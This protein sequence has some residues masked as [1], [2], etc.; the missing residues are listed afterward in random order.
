MSNP[1]K[2]VPI[3]FYHNVWLFF[4]LLLPLQLTYILGTPLPSNFV[5][6][7]KSGC[8]CVSVC[9]PSLLRSQPWCHVRLTDCHNKSSVVLDTSLPLTSRP[10]NSTPTITSPVDI[11]RAPYAKTSFTDTRHSEDTE[12]SSALLTDTQAETLRGFMHY[13]AEFLS[14]VVSPSVPT[15]RY[16]QSKPTRDASCECKEDIVGVWDYCVLPAHFN[17]D[18][19]SNGVE[20]YATS[21]LRQQR[22]NRTTNGL[23]SLFS[24]SSAGAS[25]HPDNVFQKNSVFQNTFLKAPTGGCHPSCDTCLDAHYPPETG[26]LRCKRMDERLYQ[27]IPLRPS[28]PHGSCIPITNSVSHCHMSCASCLDIGFPNNASSCVTCPAGTFFSPGVVN[29]VGECIEKPSLVTSMPF[30]ASSFFESLQNV[31]DYSQRSWLQVTP[32]R[33][34]TKLPSDSHTGTNRKE[35]DVASLETSPTLERFDSRI[36]SVPQRLTNGQRHSWRNDD[37]R[38]RG[39]S[40]I[41]TPSTPDKLPFNSL[42]EAEQNKR[43]T[44]DEYNINLR[45]SLVLTEASTEHCNAIREYL[46]RPLPV[47]SSSSYPHYSGNE[48]AERYWTQLV[49]LQADTNIQESGI[50]NMDEMLHPILPPDFADNLGF[51][52]PADY[53]HLVVLLDTRQAFS[54]AANRSTPFDTD[55]SG[56]RQAF[57]QS[58]E[59]K[60]TGDSKQMWSSLFSSSRSRSNDTLPYQLQHLVICPNLPIADHVRHHTIDPERG[61]AFELYRV[62]KYDTTQHR[63]TANYQ[64]LL[65][66]RR[67]EVDM[68]NPLILSDFISRSIQLFPASYVS[69][70]LWNHGAAWRG[71]GDD[72]DNADGEGM[73]LSTIAQGLEQ[74][75]EYPRQENILNRLTLLGFDACL[76]SEFTVVNALASYTDYFLAS[77]DNEPIRGWDWRFLNPVVQETKVDGNSWFGAPMEYRAATPVEYASQIIKGYATTEQATLRL[78]NQML[79]RFMTLSLIEISAFER[80]RNHFYL[81]CE[82]LYACGGHRISTHIQRVVSRLPSIAAC[83]TLGLCHCM[84]MDRFLTSLIEELLAEGMDRRIV[85][86]VVATRE[87]YHQ[88]VIYDVERHWISSAGGAVTQPRYLVQQENDGTKIERLRSGLSLYFPSHE[89]QCANNTRSDMNAAHYQELFDTGWSQFLRRVMS[90]ERGKTCTAFYPS[91]RLAL[92][93]LESSMSPLVNANHQP[94][95]PNDR[96]RVGITSVNI[97]VSSSGTVTPVYEILFSGWVPRM[98]LATR[99]LVGVTLDRLPSHL[100]LRQIDQQP[101]VLLTREVLHEKH[102]PA[103]RLLKDDEDVAFNIQGAWDISH[104]VLVQRWKDETV[105]KPATDHNEDRL[106]APL[107][108]LHTR[109]LTVEIPG[110]SASTGSEPES[111][112]FE[113][114]HLASVKYYASVSDLDADVF[115]LGYLLFHWPKRDTPIRLILRSLNGWSLQSAE[116]VG[117]IRPILYLAQTEEYIRVVKAARGQLMEGATKPRRMTSY[118]VD[119][120]VVFPWTAASAGAAASQFSFA[121]SAASPPPLA[122]DILKWDHATYLSHILFPQQPAAAFSKENEF[123]SVVGFG[124]RRAGDLQWDLYLFSIPSLVEDGWPFC[125]AP[126]RTPAAPW[127][128]DNGV[129]DVLVGQRDC[130]GHE[131]PRSDMEPHINVDETSAKQRSRG[132]EIQHHS[133]FT[134]HGSESYDCATL[135]TSG[136]LV[137]L[138]TTVAGE[139]KSSG[140]STGLPDYDSDEGKRRPCGECGP[141]AICQSQQHSEDGFTQ[142]KCVC[143]EGY[144]LVRQKDLESVNN[145]AT[146]AVE[147]M[148]IN[149]CEAHEYGSSGPCDEGST[150]VN[151]PGSYACLCTLGYVEDDVTLCVKEDECIGRDRYGDCLCHPGFHVARNEGGWGNNVPYYRER[152]IVGSEDVSNIDF[153]RNGTTL[154][155]RT[156]KKDSIVSPLPDKVMMRSSVECYDIDECALGI[157]SCHPFAQCFNLKGGYACL[158]EDG[159]EGDG[160]VCVPGSPSVTVVLRIIEPD[161]MLG[162]P[163]QVRLKT[164]QDSAERAPLNLAVGD[165]NNNISARNRLTNLETWPESLWLATLELNE[166]QAIFATALA[167]ALGISR[168]RVE[169]AEPLSLLGEGNGSAANQSTVSIVEEMKK[170]GSPVVYRC[171]LRVLGLRTADLTRSQRQRSVVRFPWRLKTEENLPNEL[172]SYQVALELR[173]QLSSEPVVYGNKAGSEVKSASV[174]LRDPEVVGPGFARLA[175]HTVFDEYRFDEAGGASEDDSFLSRISRWYK[176]CY[177]WITTRL[178]R[179]TPTQAVGIVLGVTV[180]FVAAVGLCTYRCCCYRRYPRRV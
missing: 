53:M 117:F 167:Q 177:T 68:N 32:L 145:N 143:K 50:M 130:Q 70:V 132:V 119:S 173:R 1:T 41:I 147:C 179:F 169:L 114:V 24:Q 175:R 180:P 79:G 157:A 25:S 8:P 131:L 39:S 171:V 94:S 91:S 144:E 6:Y 120:R 38:I 90:A 82:L 63:F 107:F 98:V 31:P 17:P 83:T 58:D 35:L 11:Q 122:L 66:R 80:F 75:L 148:D 142:W 102:E 46:Q 57:V 56:S 141:H 166:T 156:A 54:T 71:I 158:C 49:Y 60:I 138:A 108:V 87:L 163:W 47:K 45:K 126:R 93:V 170:S 13:I 64:W 135:H 81:V 43:Q 168:W 42:G 113:N 86:E 152:Q 67:G 178:S 96:R 18:P 112:T 139:I 97:S 33:G 76:M 29:T 37:E 10:W 3:I 7:S 118:A 40:S 12:V 125:I 34:K 110:A 26:C 159:Y 106:M 62:R 2:I 160:R 172:T 51:R 16:L 176:S 153:E 103:L 5:P 137:P 72:T 19:F 27:L 124:I 151:L 30:P 154:R 140:T 23:N 52:Y 85:S 77:E 104:F 123:R 127:W 161:H 55:R 155:R 15:R 59:H 21:N 99:T 88:M 116:V 149:E 4:A 128:D 111:Y 61:E 78:N 105:T 74:G 162:A 165:D 84:D 14:I 92:H 134:Q 69:L 22:W 44:A 174:A 95:V 65:L 100:T 101:A 146:A 129:C 73:A 115:Q 28:T 48:V 36:E 121:S 133:E 89:G 109:T 9:A 20:L 136:W 150:C 164:Q